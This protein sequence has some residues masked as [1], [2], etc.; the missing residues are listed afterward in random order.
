MA[1]NPVC[2]ILAAGRSE[3]MGFDKLA[4]PLANG[5][6][7]LENTVQACEAYSSVVVTSRELS[8]Q[9]ALHGKTVI[10]NE[11]PERGMTYSL[12]LADAQIDAQ[13]FIAIVPADLA[14]VDAALLET[15]FRQAGD[16]D[17]AYP[18]RA[19]GT[20]GHPVVFSPKARRLLA[21]LPD[22]D[23]LRRVRESEG[24]KKATIAIEDE[25][26]YR[27]IDFPHEFP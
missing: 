12:K 24:L 3:R 18:A 10:V 2:V 21:D 25:R 16:A 27:D 22:G 6:T 1:H 8:T 14:L 9:P 17:V 15:V 5:G 19:D 4:R 7:L 26:P 11:S 13:A 20:P 23:T